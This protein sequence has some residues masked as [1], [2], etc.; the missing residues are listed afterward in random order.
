MAER[1]YGAAVEQTVAAHH[2]TRPM[3]GSDAQPTS[4]HSARSAA[5]AAAA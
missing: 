3:R 1:S 2:I 5:A 4:Y